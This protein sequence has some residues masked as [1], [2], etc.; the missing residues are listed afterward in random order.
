MVDLRLGDYRC[1]MPT[2]RGFTRRNAY[3]LLKVKSDI[4]L[5]IGNDP[6]FPV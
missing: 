6:N 4:A 1:D 2:L 3:G 5:S